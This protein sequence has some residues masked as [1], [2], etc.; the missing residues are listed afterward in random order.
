MSVEIRITAIFL[1]VFSINLFVDFCLGSIL[2]NPIANN[3]S[4]INQSFAVLLPLTA[5]FGAPFLSTNT[6]ASF[7][8]NPLS[9]LKFWFS[10]IF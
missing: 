4:D 3:G 1:F 2:L 8:D 9:N 6:L 7:V 5:I 10:N